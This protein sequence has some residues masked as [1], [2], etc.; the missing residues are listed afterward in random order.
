L[1][2][3]DRQQVS[4]DQDESNLEGVWSEDMM[5]APNQ[6]ALAAGYSD[7]SDRWMLCLYIA[8]RRIKI[9]HTYTRA[10]ISES[11]L[12]LHAWPAVCGDA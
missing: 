7:S 8:Y 9:D 6:L 5:A 10:C 11:H 2:R 12:L 3:V 1:V 4:L